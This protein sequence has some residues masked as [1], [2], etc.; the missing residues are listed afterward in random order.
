MTAAVIQLDSRG[1]EE[2]RRHWGVCVVLGIASLILGT[3]ALGASGIVTLA[4]VLF[5]GWMLVFGGA[6]Q[7]VHAF[8]FR[9]WGGFFRHLLG[10]VL[11]IVVGG[12]LVARPLAGAES[13]TLLLAAFFVVGGAFRIMSALAVRFP[14]WGWTL[15]SGVIT[16]LLGIIIWRQWP[17]S[18]LW[19]IGTFVGIDLIFDGWSLVMLGTT[20]RQQPA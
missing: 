9:R 7:A 2:L 5:F 13:I 11:G 14:S 17:I 10:G 12:L 8:W 1:T 20:A 3:V 4:S 18:G 19:V 6:V 15:M 16:L